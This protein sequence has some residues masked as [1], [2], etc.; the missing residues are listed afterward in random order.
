MRKILLRSVGTSI[1]LAIP[2]AAALSL[3]GR[4]TIRILFEHGEFTTTAGDL[5]YRVLV[6]YAIALPAYVVTEV[7]TRGLISLR[8]TRTPLITNS[9]QLI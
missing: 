6:A 5:T 3:L 7:I 4:P 1:A 9:A 8:D 2:A